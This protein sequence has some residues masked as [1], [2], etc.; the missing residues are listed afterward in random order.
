MQNVDFPDSV[1][2]PVIQVNGCLNLMSP[3]MNA[4]R[5]HSLPVY[6]P[7]R[8]GCT[9]IQAA[10]F[11]ERP[12]VRFFPRLAYNMY[13]LSTPFTLDLIWR[14]YNYSSVLIG[15]QNHVFHLLE[16]DQFGGA[17]I[18]RNSTHFAQS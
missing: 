8:E 15:C 10:S 5:G 12:S 16:I 1:C 17:K 9:V 18:K 7:E 3:A 4:R 2:P 6:I 14:T 11:Q 13:S